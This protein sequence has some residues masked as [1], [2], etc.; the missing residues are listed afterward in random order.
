MKK[1]FFIKLSKKDEKMTL[2][3]IA[4]VLCFSMLILVLL[5]DFF[6]NKSIKSVY[7]E[8]I[9]VNLFYV[10]TVIFFLVCLL[11][12]NILMIIYLKFKMNGEID[13]FFKLN[14]ILFIFI[15]GFN[16]VST[17]TLISF[18]INIY[19][20]IEYAKTFSKNKKNFWFS[21]LGVFI[22]LF[23]TVFVGLFSDHNPFKLIILTSLLEIL[24]I[25]IYLYN[26][27]INKI[28]SIN[29]LFLL[30][31]ETTILFS[32][33]ESIGI[34]LLII[35]ILINLRTIFPRIKSYTNFSKI[36]KIILFIGILISLFTKVYIT[37]KQQ[38]QI[39]DTPKQESDGNYS[40]E[41]NTSE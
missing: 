26:K 14:Y 35:T 23:F 31:M 39:I 6:W 12:E 28:P 29:Y 5:K 13:K 32:E 2:L 3:K 4:T 8:K 9:F 36:Q 33:I 21:L 7:N 22:V 17:I 19:K 16:S 15:I 24:T 18:I 10:S 20:C 34:L 25:F 11:V 41:N 37:E 30:L 27:K 38:K 1:D 40:N